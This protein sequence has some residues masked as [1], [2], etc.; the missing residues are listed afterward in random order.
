MIKGIPF[1]GLDVK[2]FHPS[3]NRK[4]VKIIQGETRT[5]I[6][7]VSYWERPIFI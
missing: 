7:D 4:Q 3:A 6:R 1:G 2:V 5:I